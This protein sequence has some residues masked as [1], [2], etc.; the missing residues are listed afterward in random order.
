MQIT[1]VNS[2]Q[3]RLGEYIGRPSVLGNPYTI[4]RRT[5]AEVIAQ[6]RQWLRQEWVK[7]GAVQAELLRLARLAKAQQTLT[8]RCWC[9]PRA[10]HGDVV[11]EALL[12]I[13]Q[14]E[15]V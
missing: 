5:R 2:Q 14:H 3:T 9:A 12:G 8:L 1:V 15:L 10:C 13:L 4:G 6:Y 7:K 11:R